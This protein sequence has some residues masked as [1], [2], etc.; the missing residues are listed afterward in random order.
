MLRGTFWAALLFTSINTF[1][2]S[3]P[4]TDVV[5]QHVVN[6]CG[7]ESTPELRQ[8]CLVDSIAH[9]RDALGFEG[10]NAG[11]EALAACARA[12]LLDGVKRD[13]LW[14]YV[15]PCAT[16]QYR[17]KTTHPLPNL[18]TAIF[19][20]SRYRGEWLYACRQTF[21]TDV[22]GCLK[23]SQLEF[24]K[25]WQAYLRLSDASRGSQGVRAF[26]RCL[27][28]HKIP[29]FKMINLCLS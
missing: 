25:F 18:S 2:V 11:R 15:L 16:E 19:H 12:S 22:S 23:E 20:V 9:Y 6:H 4:D 14:F 17:L 5:K 24:H 10:T 13:Q 26:E 7:A 21:G 1:A 27:D 8:A 28:K 29:D 3:L